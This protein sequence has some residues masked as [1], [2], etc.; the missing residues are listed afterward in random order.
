MEYNSFRRKTKS[1]KV[2]SV[3]IGGDFPVSIQSMTNTKTIDF[4]ATYRQVS[5]LETAGC[6][7]V[8]LAVPDIESAASFR[9]LKEAGIKVPLVADIH[10][11]YKIALAALEAGAD[12]IRINPGN[13]GGKEKIAAVVS[14]CRERGVPIRI[15]VNSGSLEKHI[16]EKYGAPAAEALAESALYHAGL[17]EELG[18]SDIVI[19]VKASD[20]KTM[21]DANRILAEKTDYPLHLGVTEAGYGNRGIIKSSIGIGALLS[22]GVGDT[23]RVSLTDDPTSEVRAAK[24]ILDSLGIR[25]KRG[26]D[27]VSC[28]TCGRTKIDLIP[29]VREFEERVE[30]EGLSELNL[31][32][33]LMGCAV[34]GPGEAREA[35]IGIAGGAGEALLFRHGETV[36]KIKENDL[37]GEL[38]REIKQ[39]SK[40]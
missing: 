3:G 20:T 8:R 12:K 32:V 22:L 23:V 38:I 27:I 17:L 26:M 7:I 13:I 18:F 35:D 19:S 36:R 14:A 40:A 10:F 31:K 33:A 9:K 4:S 11:D 5:A 16:L 6:D 37:V 34:N 28:P 1:L 30:K 15:G 21:I 39:M 25:E 24:D 2:G 29:L